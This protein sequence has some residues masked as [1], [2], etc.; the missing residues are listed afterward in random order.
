MEDEKHKKCYMKQNDSNRLKLKSHKKFITNTISSGSKFIAVL[1]VAATLMAS[2]G[3]NT[4][5]NNTIQTE[6]QEEEIIPAEPVKPAKSEVNLAGKW[7]SKD[8]KLYPVIEFKGKSTVVI[9]TFLGIFPSSYE[10][11]EE[12][13]RVRTDKSDLLFE[14][15]S[16][17]S[18]V[19]SGYAKGVWI[20][21]N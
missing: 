17:D 16:E 3:N 14:V 8:N 19:G 10:R 13:I 4:T 7:R 12:Y 21:E 20:R 9:S 18:I 11:D 2:C 15:V 1:T 5:T 6:E